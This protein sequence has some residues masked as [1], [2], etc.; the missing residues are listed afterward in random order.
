MASLIDRDFLLAGGLSRALAQAARDGLLRLTTE[1]ERVASRDR[2]L[3]AGW[4]EGSDLWVF[5]YGSLMWN[6]AFHFIESRTATIHGFHRRFCLHSVVGRGTPELPGLMLGLDRGGSCRGI[7]LR[8][9]AAQV[10]EELDIIWSREMVSDAYR[11]VW[12][13]ARTDAGPVPS[14]AF[15]IDESL[16]TYAG[17]LPIDEVARRIARASGPM[18][19]CADYLFETVAHLEACG[20]RDR[21]LA[22]ILSRV[23]QAGGSGD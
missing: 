17:R 5:A 11:P 9:A 3:A 14:I 7:V 19:H 20:I 4:Q 13:Q 16:P 22:Q 23:R 21:S 12:V 15:A 6:P 2:M 18:G 1:Q 10:H 8:I